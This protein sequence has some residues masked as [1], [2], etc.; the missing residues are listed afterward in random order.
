[1]NDAR[2][3]RAG[4]L[5]DGGG[6]PLQRNVLLRMKNGIVTGITPYESNSEID[7]LSITDLSHAVLCPPFIDCHVHLALSGTTD[8]QLR[9]R[10]AE[11]SHSDIRPL[12]RRHIDDLFAHGV[13][14][15][16]DAD[17]RP[18][19]LQRYGKEPVTAGVPP[20][21]ILAAGQAEYGGGTVIVDANGRE[22]V[23]T[24]IAAGCQ[25]IVHGCRMG[26]D[27]LERMAER[28]VV[29]VPTLQAMK[30]AAEQAADA[31]EKKLAANALKAQLEQVALARQL[32]VTVALGTDSGSPGVL[33]GE[34]VVEEM[35][36]LI[37]AGFSLGGAISCAT[38]NGAAL[39][40][41]VRG[42][43]AVGRQADFLVAR[44][45]PAQLPRKFSYLEGIWLAGRPSP[46]YRK[47]PQRSE[48]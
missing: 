43:I 28:G 7:S 42:R 11:S 36:L 46:N 14:A 16:R 19:F 2:A 21:V 29:L 27:N 45:T 24:A 23:R 35:K 41:L 18:G 47:N 44:G 6:G 40:G 17:D 31:A 3:V 1:M 12:I 34:A 22:P 20:V 33:H 26:R 15:V 10:L 13:L 38:V 32:G 9:R 37:Q 4:W 8:L 30:V 25:A 48:R 5:I 39:L